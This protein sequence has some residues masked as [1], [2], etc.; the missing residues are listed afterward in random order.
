MTT[1]KKETNRGLHRMPDAVLHG[2][3]L[4]IL[5]VISNWLITHMLLLPTRSPGTTIYWEVYGPWLRLYS[6]I[7][8]ARG[9][10]RSS[11]GRS[12]GHEQSLGT[13]PIRYSVG[14]NLAL[15][16]ACFTV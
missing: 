9:T 10:A 16:F 13:R 2:I 3:A 11:S 4:S 14:R 12:S 15:G 6:S 7:A 1:Q 5:C 8:S